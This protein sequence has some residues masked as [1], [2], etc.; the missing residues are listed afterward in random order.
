M[1]RLIQYLTILVAA[2]ITLS[3]YW[4]ANLGTSGVQLDFS[5]V[6]SKAAGDVVRVYLLADG[7][8]LSVGDTVPYVEEALGSGEQ[9]ITIE[10]LPV[11]PEYQALVGVGNA[12]GLIFQVSYYGESKT[13]ELSSGDE[14][15]VPVTMKSMP[16]GVTHSTDLA[17]KELKGVVYSDTNFLYTAEKSRIYALNPGTLAIDDVAPYDQFGA[18]SF[19]GNSLSESAA[20][21]WQ[22]FINTD[23]GILPF[24]YFGEDWIF[25]SDFSTALGGEKNLQESGVFLTGSDYNFFF[26]RKNGLGGVSVI[27]DELGSPGTWRWVNLELDGVLDMACSDLY[28]YYAAS[29]GAFALPPNILADTTPSIVEHRLNFSAPAKILSLAIIPKVASPS[30]IYLGTMNG[31]WEGQITEDDPAVDPNISLGALSQVAETAGYGITQITVSSYFDYTAYLSRYY[32]FIR[33][34]GLVTRFPF[35]A[36]IPGKASG[37]DWSNDGVTLYIAGSEGLSSLYIGC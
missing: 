12:A 8:L 10:D 32:L 26:R 11:G 17:G 13:F 37:L 21:D 9:K 25:N 16:Y 24:D 15:T 29:G 20:S 36:V 14:I 4:T 27:S 34:D 2:V 18:Q 35:F 23:N 5:N 30:E 22:G 6:Q 33:E 31:A 3:C 7:N 1:K 19:Q 28:A